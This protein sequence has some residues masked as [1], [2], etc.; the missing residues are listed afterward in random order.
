MF[1][2]RTIPKLTAVFLKFDKYQP[3]I[4]I[5]YPLYQRPKYLQYVFAW[6][7]SSLQTVCLFPYSYSSDTINKIRHSVF[8]NLYAT[9]VYFA[10]INT[11]SPK[12]LYFASF[13]EVCSTVSCC[14]GRPCFQIVFWHNLPSGEWQ[15][16][17]VNWGA[18]RGLRKDPFRGTFFSA[19]HS[20]VDD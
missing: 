12:L 11:W 2:L 15:P 20:S 4:I 8:N 19:S 14:G 9:N 3:P 17:A 5:P 13:F 6:V 7:S 10:S 18:F 16:T 1:L